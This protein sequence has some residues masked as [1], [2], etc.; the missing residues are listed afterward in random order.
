MQETIIISYDLDSGDT[1]NYNKLFEYIKDFGTWAHI[2]ESLWAI[3]TGKSVSII[4]DELLE[5]VPKG[6]SLFVT[7]S[8]A[9]AAW[10]NVQCSNKW[11]KDNL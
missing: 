6:S 11:L 1:E 5:I 9:V 2:T 4:R 3:K 8:S 7:K 10:S